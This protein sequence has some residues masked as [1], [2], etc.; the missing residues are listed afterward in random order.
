MTCAGGHEDC[1]F[2]EKQRRGVVDGLTD[3][4]S[5]PVSVLSD[6]VLPV[7]SDDWWLGLRVVLLARSGRRF[8]VFGGLLAPD[9]LELV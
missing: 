4:V 1:H 3:R 7:R 8:F 9:A 2:D 5:R 6:C